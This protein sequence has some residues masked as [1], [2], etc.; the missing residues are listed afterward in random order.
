[1]TGLSALPVDSVTARVEVAETT[2]IVWEDATST[3]SSLLT[4]RSGPAPWLAHY[5]IY[6]TEIERVTD[7]AASPDTAPYKLLG[8]CTANDR[9]RH[10]IKYLLCNLEANE[11]KV[12]MKIQPVYKS[13]CACPLPEIP[14]IDAGKVADIDISSGIFSKEKF[15]NVSSF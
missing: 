11:N 4:W 14:P 6:Y 12:F 8:S 1:M 3:I 9:G 15:C 7:S 2:T 5:N 13:G 10:R